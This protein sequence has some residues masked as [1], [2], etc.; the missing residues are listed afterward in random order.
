MNYNF[1]QKQKCYASLWGF[2]VGDAM[3]VPYEFFER[4]E[5]KF[6]PAIGMKG[7]ETHFQPPGTWSDDTSMMLCVI[8]NIY[9]GWDSVN[10]SKLFIK[11]YDEAYHTSH[12]EVFDIGITTRQALENIKAG[13]TYT[14]AGLNDD[15]SA[16]NG[17]LMRS[18]P[19]AFINPFD[20]SILK[21][22]QEGQITHRLKICSDSCVL[23]INF[24]RHLSEGKSKEE[25]L[26]LSC[27]FLA[28]EI[29]IE[30]NLHTNKKPNPFARL[31]SKDFQHLPEKEIKSTGYV[32]HS[33]EASIWSFMNSSN[34]EHAVLNAVNL[35]G[36]TD[37]IA[38]LA[39][40][41]AGGYYGLESI[42]KDWIEVIAR[43][44]ELELMMKKW[45]FEN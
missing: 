14:E 42:P 11:W 29:K 20:I 30:D 38:A 6:E 31:M 35:G 32:I 9:R 4:E 24:L 27:E 36:D 19:Y 18:L 26:Y 44:Q 21:A 17:S 23:Y 15:R 28:Q 39:G 41:I 43:R 22:I 10:L 40:G 7:F 25:S 5:M 45:V 8:E 3:G 16:G 33:L 37:T 12:N 2:I 34:Y 1:I 13:I